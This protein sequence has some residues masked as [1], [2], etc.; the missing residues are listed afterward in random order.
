MVKHDA[1]TLKKLQSLS[2][3]DK[4]AL[5]QDRIIEFYEHYDGKVVVS[6]SGGK[7]STVLLHIA[8]QLF[9]EYQGCVFEY[10]P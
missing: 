6:F 7:D 9:S 5:T 3:S 1:E 4:V 8:R 10:G 2:L